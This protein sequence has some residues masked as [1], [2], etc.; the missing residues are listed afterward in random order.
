M[1]E[2]YYEFK[3]SPFTRQMTEDALFLTEEY[4]EILARLQYAARKQ[5]FALL[6]GDCGTGFPTVWGPRTTKCSTWQ[7]PN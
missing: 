1:I 5:W 7:T 6:T 2:E 4:E 3:K